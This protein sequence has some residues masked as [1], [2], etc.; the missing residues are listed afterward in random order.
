MKHICHV[1][2]IYLVLYLNAHGLHY[3]DSQASHTSVEHEQAF[4]DLSGN[5]IG[6]S[7]VLR[8]SINNVSETYYS[9]AGRIIL[10]NWAVDHISYAASIAI[11]KYLE[12]LGLKV[13]N[14][15]LNT[16][17]ILS[18]R[19]YPT[20]APTSHPSKSPSSEPTSQPSSVPS[21]EPSPIPSGLP[22][23]QPSSEPRFLCSYS[24]NT[25]LYVELIFFF[26]A[27]L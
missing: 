16:T 21:Q 11:N 26:L 8:V 25:Q 9:V 24:H 13:V 2:I 3:F 20:S 10:H 6:T 17:L 19:R 1:V 5:A 12:N 7:Q 15:Q 18:G 23:G 27:F 4:S 22:S 14:I